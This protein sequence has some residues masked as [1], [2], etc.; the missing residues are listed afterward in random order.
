MKYVLATHDPATEEFISE[1]PFDISPELV[2]KLLNEHPCGVFE[3][4]KELDPLFADLDDNYSHF[5]MAVREFEGET[6]S[7]NGVEYFPAPSNEEFAK[8][9]PGAVPIMPKVDESFIECDVEKND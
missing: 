5:L 8:M 1:R 9:V 6:Y 4:T 3:I 2:N 7:F